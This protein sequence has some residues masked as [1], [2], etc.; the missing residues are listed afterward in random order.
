M[1]LL[2]KHTHTHTTLQKL[3]TWDPPNLVSFGERGLAPNLQT[4]HNRDCEK[5]RPSVENW[6]LQRLVSLRRFQISSEDVLKMLLK[7]QLRQKWTSTPHFSSKA[8]YWKG[9]PASI[10]FLNITRCPSMKK[11][12]ENKKGKEWRKIAHIP[13]IKIDDKSSITKIKGT[14]QRRKICHIKMSLTCSSAL[15]MQIANCGTVMIGLSKANDLNVHQL[16]V[17]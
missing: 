5:L 13:C 1:K 10:S 9:F 17:H 11:R 16:A 7:E 4:F 6:G 3:S 14:G 2:P 8:I 12:Y 15:L